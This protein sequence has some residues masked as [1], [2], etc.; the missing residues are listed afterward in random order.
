[1]RSKWLDGAMRLQHVHTF[2]FLTQSHLEWQQ[3]LTITNLHNTSSNEQISSHHNDNDTYCDKFQ[4]HSLITSQNI[5]FQPVA[6]EYKIEHN[7]IQTEGML[8]K[9]VIR[10]NSVHCIK[11]NIK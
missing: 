4:N 2:L 7:I 1:M 11:W 8:L 5:F 6:E 10:K 9:N 3:Q